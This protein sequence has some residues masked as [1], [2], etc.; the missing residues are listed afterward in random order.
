MEFVIGCTFLILLLFC[1]TV[2]IDWIIYRLRLI[3]WPSL[4]SLRALFRSYSLGRLVSG[5]RMRRI[6]GR[7][8]S[9]GKLRVT[10]ARWQSLNES[11]KE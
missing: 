1:C 11:E 2:L 4:S 7:G 3:S 6:S 9:L 5:F 10:R 8:P